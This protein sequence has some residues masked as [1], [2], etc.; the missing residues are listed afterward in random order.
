MPMSSPQMTRMLGFCCANA[1]IAVSAKAP[2]SANM[3]WHSP[4]VQLI[5]ISFIACYSYRLSWRDGH[6]APHH[7]RT[8]VFPATGCRTLVDLHGIVRH[9]LEPM[10]LVGDH[11]EAPVPIRPIQL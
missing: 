6:T 1:G 7:L 9:E 3:P 11:H 5:S 2:N 10:L 4:R 8:F